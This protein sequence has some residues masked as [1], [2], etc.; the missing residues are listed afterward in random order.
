MKWPGCV[1]RGGRGRLGERGSPRLGRP[2]APAIVLPG[3]RPADG[4]GP[5]GHPEQARGGETPL[6][7]GWRV[8]GQ[9]TQQNRGSRGERRELGE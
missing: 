1:R 7:A 5:G 6:R 9:V 4:A 2:A 3:G 8:C